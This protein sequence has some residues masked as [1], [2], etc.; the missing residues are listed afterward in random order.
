MRKLRELGQR[1]AALTAMATAKLNYYLGHKTARAGMLMDA[2]VANS[3]RF[4][5]H[6]SQ[7]Q[8]R[9]DRRRHGY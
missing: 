1:V 2:P 4:I 7:R 8:L 9:R 5:H 3:W 6:R